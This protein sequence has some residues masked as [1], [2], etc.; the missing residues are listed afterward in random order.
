[1][2][3]IPGP[4][5]VAGVGPGLRT[6][7]VGLLL[8]TARG[9]AA[10]GPAYFQ[11]VYDSSHPAAAAFRPDFGYAVIVRYDG[12]TVLL[13]TGTDPEV[14]LHNLAAAEIPLATVDAVVM[15][16]NHADHAG[17]LSRIRQQAPNVAVWVP[18]GQDFGIEPVR[19]VEDGHELTPNVLIVRGHTDTPTAGIADDLSLVLRTVEGAYVLSSCSHSGL[20]NILDR[21]EHAAGMKTHYVSGGARLVFRPAQ[22]AQHMAK[23]LKQR[24]LRFVSPSHC[25]LSH[26]TTEIFDRELGARHVPSRLGARV[27]LPAPPTPAAR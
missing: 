24:D 27:P 20:F 15:T 26:R 21:A 22:D 12:A 19:V 16:H 11:I 18:P 17:G 14:L 1:M 4:N 23:A 13:D 3:A 8:L 2:R 10:A 6:V 9:T 25:S 5:A 7:C